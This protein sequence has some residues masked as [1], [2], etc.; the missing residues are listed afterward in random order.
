VQTA[1]LT[2]DL[3]GHPPKLAAS[4]ETT[5]VR[6]YQLLETSHQM[7]GFPP[8]TATVVPDVKLESGSASMT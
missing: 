8:V 1:S 7:N 3:S 6:S 4:D 5:S 2:K